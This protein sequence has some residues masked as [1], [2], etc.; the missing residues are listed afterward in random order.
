[1]KG[2]VAGARRRGNGYSPART[3]RSISATWVSDV[4]AL[5]HLWAD[6]TAEQARRREGSAIRFCEIAGCSLGRDHGRT[7][8]A[9]ISVA[10][11][12]LTLF[13]AAP[14]RATAAKGV[15]GRTQS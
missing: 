6:G 11:L 7:T 14:S 13:I 9:S 3:P 8:R 1:M 5:R 10:R 2:A 12:V 15:E 4:E